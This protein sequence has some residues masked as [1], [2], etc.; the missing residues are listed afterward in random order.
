MK[1]DVE[2]DRCSCNIRVYNPMMIRRIAAKA[3]QPIDIRWRG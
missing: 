2:L 3:Q 1:I